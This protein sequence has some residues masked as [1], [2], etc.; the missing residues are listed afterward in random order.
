MDGPDFTSV[1][2]GAVRGN[3]YVGLALAAG[4][5]GDAGFAIA[6]LAFAVIVPLVNVLS[7]A[8]LA[9]HGGHTSATPWTAMASIA[10]NPLV[11]ACVAGAT[12]SAAAIPQPDLIHRTL[13]R[14]GRPALPLGLLTV[15]AALQFTALGHAL[16]PL[17]LSS[18]FKLVLMPLLVRILC[19]WLA[20]DPLTTATLTLLAALP[21]ATSSYIL[22]R[23]LG[24]N[25][26]LMALVISCQTVSAALTL[27]LV[28]LLLVPA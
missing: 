25:A 6:S 14:L 5:L 7:V 2:Q 21:T 8:V 1:F 18:A 13:E 12:L 19:H 10:R 24:G 22:A 16:G 11:L 27:P 3:T 20:V 9:S 4:L 28:H 26:P 15:G 23:Q 17:A